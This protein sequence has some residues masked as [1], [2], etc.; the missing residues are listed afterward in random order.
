MRKKIRIYF[1]V[2]L[3]ALAVAL[4]GCS[5]KSTDTAKNALY[6]KTDVTGPAASFDWN[7]KVG[8]VSYEKTYVETNSGK[9]VTTTLDGVK[10]AADDLEKKK[11]E[12]TNPKVQAALKLVDAVFVNQKNF[13][14]VLKARGASNQEEFFDKLWNDVVAPVLSERYATFSKDTVFKYKGESYSLKVYAPMFF[15][16][17]TNALG[18]AGAYTLEDYKVEGD[19]VYLKF[20]APSVDVYQYEVK[21]S[22][23]QDNQEFFQGLI[24]EHN[25][26]VETNYSKGLIIRFVY[27]LAALDFKADNYVNL[28]GMDYYDTSTHYLAIKVD[29]KGNAKIDKENIAN[30]LQINMKPANEANKG[31]FE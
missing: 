11:K 15:K 9:E 25:K 2:S 13:D 23:H 21:A 27:Q 16:V 22:Y 18:K 17:N 19:M 31:K 7:V 28:Q 30:L 1:L 29:S 3:I 10:K 24:D 4:V 14:L 8:P 5:S 26:V 6:H 12:I 20:K